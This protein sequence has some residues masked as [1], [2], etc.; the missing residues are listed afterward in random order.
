VKLI[1]YIKEEE[2]FKLVKAEKKDK[3]KLAYKLAFGSG[4]RISEIIGYKRKTP[5]GK[6]LLLDP[7]EGHG[8]KAQPSEPLEI[9]PLHKEQIDLQAKTI[10][11]IGGKGMKDRIVPL[12]P[13]FKESD[14]K[15]LPLQIKRSTL[16]AHFKTLGK[17]VLSRDVTFHQLRHGFGV[18]STKKRVPMPFIQQAMGH[19]RL[20]TTGIYTAASPEDM[21][22]GYKRAWGEI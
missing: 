11:V 1:N 16:Q 21:L 4:L 20:D 8:P 9:Q 2:F 14:L 3:F 5:I 18:A 15:L 6:G 7:K 10:K 22:E 19:S 13:G 17:K 12:F